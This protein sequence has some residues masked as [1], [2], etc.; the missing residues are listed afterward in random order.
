[1]FRRA[2]QMP[3]VHESIPVSCP[4]AM[5]D[6]CVYRCI[7][8]YL[9][10]LKHRQAFYFYIITHHRINNCIPLFPII[11][12]LLFIV[13]DALKVLLPCNNEVIFTPL[14]YVA[15]VATVHTSKPLDHIKHII[16]FL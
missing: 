12:S 6:W 16:S 8:M 7:Q 15:S 14:M 11:S 10:H 3:S 1:M 9:L 4:N 2:G 13:F 5:T